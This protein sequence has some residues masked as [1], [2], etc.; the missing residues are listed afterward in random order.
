MGANNPDA[1]ARGRGV[2][3]G[4]LGRVIAGDLERAGV[5]GGRKDALDAGRERLCALDWEWTDFT[6]D[7]GLTPDGAEDEAGREVGM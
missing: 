7:E 1:G 5:V 2:D 4:V 3:A 6:D